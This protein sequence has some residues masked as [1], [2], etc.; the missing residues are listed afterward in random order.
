MIED[1]NNDGISDII[2]VRPSLGSGQ[3]LVG[4]SDGIFDSPSTLNFASNIFDRGIVV[5]DFNDDHYL[6]VAVPNFYENYIRI[7]LGSGRETFTAWTTYYTGAGSMPDSLAVG[8]LDSDAHFDIVAV[9]GAN[10]SIVALLGMG[11]GLFR[12]SFTL[13]FNLTGYIQSPVIADINNDHHPDIVVV[14]T[15]NQ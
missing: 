4:R 15:W 13:S 10:N 6:D 9:L 12:R 2:V 14:N 11:F 3:L 7:W 8:D 1:M 5:A